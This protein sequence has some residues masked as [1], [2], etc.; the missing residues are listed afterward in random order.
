[1][2]EIE[3]Y[4]LRIQSAENTGKFFEMLLKIYKFADLYLNSILRLISK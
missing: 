4:L 3:I 2:P 1:M